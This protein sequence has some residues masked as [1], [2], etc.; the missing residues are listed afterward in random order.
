MKKLI[1][2]SLVLA[3]AAAAAG[4]AYYVLRRFFDDTFS[5]PGCGR[6]ERIDRTYDIPDRPPYDQFRDRILEEVRDLDERHYECVDIGS[7]DGLELAGRLY[8]PGQ[9][10]LKAV[11]ICFHGYKSA[12]LR[13]FYG[14][15]NYLID[16]GCA[17]LL[18][19]ERAQGK[20]EGGAITFG[21]REKDDAVRWSRFAIERFGPDIPLY[22]YG[23]SMGSSIVLLAAGSGE[24]PDPVKGIIADCPYSSAEAIM[25]HVIRTR[26]QPEE[27]TFRI[28]DISARL[29]GGM[30]LSEADVEAACAACRLPMLLIHG[31]DD[32]F[33]PCGMSRC[34]KEAN[35]D[36]VQLEIFPGAGHARSYLAAPERYLALLGGFIGVS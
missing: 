19:D 30:D 6:T 21:I 23:V 27:L 2:S 16:R 1:G 36:C 26:N 12:A 31:D 9:E 22:L 33:V 35:P 3:S 25:R 28:T 7:K 8:L 14:R 34:L 10:S 29:L 18:V 4:G 11:V 15:A 32:Q 5:P 20:S 13:D 17:V 24:L